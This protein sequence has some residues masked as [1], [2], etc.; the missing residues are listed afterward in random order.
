L[1]V[2]ILELLNHGPPMGLTKSS[3]KPCKEELA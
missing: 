1:A 3:G 2:A